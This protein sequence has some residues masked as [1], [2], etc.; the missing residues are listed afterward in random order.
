MR[1]SC[2]T[3]CRAR[4]STWACSTIRTRPTT[5]CSSPRGPSIARARR[6]SRRA[7]TTSLASPP[8]CR[9]STTRPATVPAWTSSTTCPIGE[10]ATVP[11]Q[12]STV[13]VFLMRRINAHTLPYWYFLLSGWPILAC[14][15]LFFPQSQ[16]GM[17]WP[18][19]TVD[20]PSY[21]QSCQQQFNLQTRPNWAAVQFGGTDFSQS[22]NISKQSCANDGGR[23]NYDVVCIYYCSIQQRHARSVAHER[24]TARP[25]PVGRRHRHT[26]GRSSLGFVVDR[27]CFACARD[28]ML[29]SLSA[30]L[31]GDHPQDP[32]YVRRARAQETIYI[33]KWIK[34]WFDTHYHLRRSTNAAPFD[35]KS[36][37]AK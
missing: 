32:V 5:A 1:S 26:R 10:P 12:S 20:I 25:E 3:T 21:V 16:S 9:T 6:S 4:S 30:D 19:T 15:D 14:G 17:W 33:T 22:S 18:H 37:F 34:E 36:V 31:R 24:H 11:T 35:P 7:R 29:F 2:R 8:V 13:P 27:F 28:V 23:L